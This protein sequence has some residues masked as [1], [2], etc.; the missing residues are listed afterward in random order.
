MLGKVLITGGG[1]FIGG[2]LWRFLMGQGYRVV[3][4]TADERCPPGITSSA[5]YSLRLPNKEFARV[6]KDFEPDWLLHCAGSASVAGSFRNP[7]R[8]F[9][10]NVAVTESVF[11]ALAQASPKTKV[12]F[13]SSG[14][15]YGEPSSLPLHE[16]CPTRPISP[17]GYHKL[18]CELI[19]RKYTSGLGI[20]SLILRVFSAYGPGLRR[21]ILWDVYQKTLGS[22][23]VVLSG[24]GRELRDFI[25]I[26]DICR[27]VHQAMR[28][29]LFDGR[30]INVASG[31]SISI[32]RLARL[33]MD[34]LVSK[35]DLKFSND[36][37]RGDPTRWELDVSA[38]RAIGMKD[39]TPIEEGVRRYAEWLRATGGG[40]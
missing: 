4:S 11:E 12:V 34:A 18:M 14:A 23:P 6:V 39:A 15:V 16:E 31:R 32:E 33:M 22:G 24:T 7:E 21:Q 27:V 5:H 28:V 40:K 25:Y 20:A 26:E 2:A 13:L 1:G 35:A 3:G 29:G 38:L 9:V 8:D 37:R 10:D 30:A 36:A 19:C 17:Y